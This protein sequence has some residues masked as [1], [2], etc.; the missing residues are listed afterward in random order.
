MLH[1]VSKNVTFRVDVTLC[2]EISSRCYN[3][4]LYHPT[5]LKNINKP[6]EVYLSEISRKHSKEYI[7]GQEILKNGCDS[8]HSVLAA[9]KY[10]YIVVQMQ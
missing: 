9:S 8:W 5:P 7:V 1:F 6:L 2:R 3:I 4:R 10:V